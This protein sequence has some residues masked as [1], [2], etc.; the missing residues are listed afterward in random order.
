MYLYQQKQPYFAQI[1]S[2]FEQLAAAELTQLGGEDIRAGFRGLYFEATPAALYRINYCARLLT[3]VLAPLVSFKCHTTQYL[4][5]QAN[6]VEWHDFLSVDQTFAVFANVSNSRIKHSRYAALRV[7]DA[8]VDYFW[9]HDR[10]RP[11]VNRLEPDVWLNLHVENNVA[12]ISL[13][14]SGGSLHRRGYRQEGLEAPMQ[15]TLAAA[16]IQLSEWD[17]ERLCYD[18]MCGSGTLLC[19]ALMHVCRIPANYLRTRFGFENLPDFDPELWQRVKAEANAALRPL[20]EGAL[21]GSDISKKAVLTAR[22]NLSQLPSGQQVPLDVRDIH[23]ILD[24]SETTIITNP[25]YGIRQEKNKDLSPFYQQLG[26]FLKQRCP[27][28]AA[29]IYFGDRHYIKKIG[30]RPTWKKPLRNG[31]LDGRLVKYDIYP[32]QNDAPQE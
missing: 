28:S 30:L 2:G 16:I 18:P 17:G 25:P 24:L 12:T 15:E 4:Y 9:E 21:A 14:T 20:P 32:L 7:K 11:S 6:A 29:H 10:Q 19:E 26:D 27:N 1:A 3:R 8:L 31:S 23:D 22:R 13:D 5:K